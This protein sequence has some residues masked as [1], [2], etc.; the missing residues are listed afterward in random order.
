MVYCLYCRVTTV[1]DQGKFRPGIALMICTDQ[2]HLRKN[3]WQKPETGIKDGFQIHQRW[4]QDR[5][6]PFSFLVL[7]FFMPVS[8]E[9]AD[10]SIIKLVSQG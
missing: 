3:C 4:L 6:F 8:V 10:S 1:N 2:I 5:F 7:N 9:Y